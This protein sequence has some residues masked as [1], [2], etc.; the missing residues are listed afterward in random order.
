MKRHYLGWLLV[1]CL[2]RSAAGAPS[3]YYNNQVVTNRTNIDAT[4][5]LNSGTIFFDLLSAATVDTAIFQ[6][7]DT[8]YYTNGPY[9]LMMAQ[10]GFNFETV[11]SSGIRPAISFYNSG[12]IIAADAPVEGFNTAGTPPILVP[13]SPSLTPGYN[14]SVGGLLS[15]SA[16]TINNSGLLGVGNGGKLQLS[17]T[18][19]NLSG[20]LQAGAVSDLDTNFNL[21]QGLMGA[22]L[23]A[24]V[25]YPYYAPVAGQYDI[26]WGF[27]NIPVNNYSSN[28]VLYLADYLDE[29]PPLIE[30][31]FPNLWSRNGILDGLVLPSTPTTG[32][33]V[34][35]EI[36][37]FS[38]LTPLSTSAPAAPAQTV[39]PNFVSYVYSYAYTTSTNANAPVTYYYNMV[40]VNSAFADS[41]ITANVRFASEGETE[42]ET[43]SNGVETIQILA[44][45]ENILTNG[46]P[47]GMAAIVQFTAPVTDVLTGQM[48]NNSIYLLDLGAI[49]VPAYE[50]ENCIYPF[51]NM[52]FNF[53]IALSEP[54]E[55]T[56]ALSANDVFD[57]TVIYTDQEFDSVTVPMTNAFYVAQ[58]GRNP[59][60][61]DGL[62]PYTRALIGSTQTGFPDITNEGGQ[63]SINASTLNISNLTLS[64]TGFVKMTAPTVV[65]T[66]A[67]V[68]C[69]NMELALGNM[70]SPFVATNLFPAS[71]HRLRGPIGAYSATWMN[72]QTND[73]LG[74]NASGIDHVTNYY[75][76]HALVVDQ[77]FRSSFQ[78]TALD[79]SLSGSKVVLD[80]PLRIMKSGVIRTTNLTVNSNLI[81]TG[82]A[83][84][85]LPANVPLMQTLLIGTNG[86]VE[87]D[88]EINLYVAPSLTQ[89]VPTV[90]NTPLQS[91][92]NLGTILSAQTEIQT[93]LLV[94]KG[95]IIATN[96]GEII[97]DAIT[98][99]LG[100][101]T[102]SAGTNGL[103]NILAAG[104]D[105]FLTSTSIQITNS[106]IWAGQ[107]ANGQL[108]LYASAELTDH[109]PG[110]T[111]TN[112]Y[113]TNFWQVNRGFTLSVKPAS[114]DLFATQLASIASNY[115]QTIV[116]VWA[117]QDR[118]ATVA[119]FTN[120]E[121]IGHLILDR[122]TNNTVLEFSAAGKS[123][124]MYVDY[125]E[126][127][128]L[129]FTDYHNGLRVDPNF[130][131]YFANA[132]VDPIKIHEVYTNIVWVPQFTGPNSTAYVEIVT[133]SGTN[134]VPVNALLR[135]SQDLS[136]FVPGT[137][138]ANVQFPIYYTNSGPNPVPPRYSITS[139]TSV[140]VSNTNGLF[141]QSFVI[142]TT[143]LGNVTSSGSLTSLQAG[144]NLTLT[145]VPASNW[146]FVNW[147]W[148][149]PVS[150]ADVTNATITFQVPTN[151]FSWVTA[152]FIL[153]PV[154]NWAGSYYGLF[155]NTNGVTVSNS[156]FVTFT[157]NSQGVFSGK[158]SLGTS[159]YPFSSQFY[160]S[161]SATAAA[162]NG[163]NR[164]IVSLQLSGSAAAGQ[165]TGSVS[166]G[167]FDSSL[168]AYPTPGWTASNSAP[169]AGSYTLVLSNANAAAG[170]GGFS[171]G[172]VAVDPLGNLT[173]IV[174]LADNATAS[175][176]V[177]M[178]KGGGW[179]LYLAPSG[180]PQSLLGWVAF[181]TNGAGGK[182]AGMTGEVT[183]VKGAG[184]GTYYGN[185][186][187]NN[188]V[189]LGSAYSAAYQRTNGLGLAN[190]SIT[191]TGGNLAGEI[192]DR[193]VASGLEIYMTADKTTLKL[194]INPTNGLFSGK[195]TPA[196]GK[197]ASLGGAVLQNSGRADGFFLGTDQSGA[198]WLQGN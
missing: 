162:T 68:D 28:D 86:T 183:W 153:N 100:A 179:P 126:L 168:V 128:D 187:T 15:V 92:T 165:A 23:V 171:Y 56:N 113:S 161:H 24:G 21:G 57:S 46:D 164:L 185:G 181:D 186:F 89:V 143:G 105:I 59:E 111:S 62:F 127:R 130:K 151:V 163:T 77:A 29:N 79:A 138:N 177:P 69:G 8:L 115:G 114:G 31:P 139:T 17:G 191:L 42:V 75:H 73:F 140:P 48:V 176:A 110:T 154:A 155:T 125:L 109:Y 5:F 2:A 12:V 112:V 169:Q 188:S 121:V 97:L 36:F 47:E 156:G 133:P 66:P 20:S 167:G 94:N 136:T 93:R 7:K 25:L 91:V 160:D 149:G 99:L 53:Q 172:T 173:A 158:L 11:T 82:A 49:E 71:F 157:L 189:L 63:I 87:A 74:T 152:N 34:P 102:M 80:D 106:Q 159:N 123:N 118:G 194:T 145:A 22:A 96:S 178:T 119:G 52:P 166:N 117:G 55:W 142:W 19:L 1:V 190:P 150:A 65:G 54:V 72:T 103:T 50:A 40:F 180:V 98:N 35:Y 83:G 135:N 64:A 90:K 13:A 45:V 141:G 37:P 26:V 197:A 84:T 134:I 196:G 137:A 198:V 70:K 9:A 195:Y 43:I 14:A 16:T 147:T 124:A 78:P 132:N 170:P 108:V 175:Q 101:G 61:S 3:F 146:L 193:V 30:L 33:P 6:T 27:T 104:S 60:D 131:I 144:Q 129:A 107:A 58:V 122:L 18:T 148:P 88:T 182:P 174:T 76:Y 32:L 38:Y 81:F 51:D 116:H 192:S 95:N 85:L 4:I 10:P 39:A 67:G 44:G 120:N 184:P 41:D